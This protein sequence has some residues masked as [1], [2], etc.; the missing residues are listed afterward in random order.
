MHMLLILPRQLDCAIHAGEVQLLTMNKTGKYFVYFT[1]LR[2][3]W[4]CSFRFECFHDI[5]IDMT[6]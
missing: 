1:L 3:F 5:K 6:C 4:Q 2:T